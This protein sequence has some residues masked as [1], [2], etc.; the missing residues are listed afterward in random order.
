MAKRTLHYIGLAVLLTGMAVAM[1]MFG[2]KPIEQQSLEPAKLDSTPDMIHIFGS[3]TGSVGEPIIG[4][5]IHVVGTNKG[6]ITDVDGVF[7][8]TINRGENIEITSIG[9][10]LL[11]PI[12]EI[13]ES[14]TYRFIMR[15]WSEDDPRHGSIVS[16]GICGD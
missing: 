6:T 5:R 8:L 12:T 13:T 11:T 2:A 9:Y 10:D 16:V 1:P 15:E 4:A 7:Q 3:I 14:G